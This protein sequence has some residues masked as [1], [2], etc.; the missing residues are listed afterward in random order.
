[1]AIP[2]ATTTVTVTRVPETPPDGNDPYDPDDPN[3]P[4]ATTVA[5]G[6]RATI[7][8][9]TANVALSGGDKVVYSA[10]FVTDPADIGPDDRLADADGTTWTVLWARPAPGFLPHIQ[11][12]ARLVVGAT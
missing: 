6:V 8:A 11:G 12:Q 3:P 10:G 4:A 1:M 5:I 9:P 7:A 2:L